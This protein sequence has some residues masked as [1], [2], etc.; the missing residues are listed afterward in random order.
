MIVYK[1]CKHIISV[2]TKMFHQLKVLLI[3]NAPDQKIFTNNSV[4]QYIAALQ[5]SKINIVAVC[6][7]QDNFR[8][9]SK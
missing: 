8:F 6:E 7:F 1:K 4:L 9:G 2:K 3:E 5:L